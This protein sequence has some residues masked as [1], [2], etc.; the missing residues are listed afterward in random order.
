[1]LVKPADWILY[2][3]T[4]QSELI[5]RAVAAAQLLLGIGHGREV[6]SHVALVSERPEW[7]YESKFPFPGHFP[8][9]ISR[10]Y[11]IWRIGDP[12]DTQRL[13]ALEWCHRH[14]GI[15]FPYNLSG[16]LTDGL[17]AARRSYVCSQYA[18]AAWHS[19]GVKVSPEG[20]RILAPDVIPDFPGARLIKRYEPPVFPVGRR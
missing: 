15:R 1:M 10:P 3:V 6:Y 17:V 12:S 20:N 13:R 2:T 4:G 11:E 9:D 18:A 19:A 16:L 8:V 7:Q 14:I 5:S